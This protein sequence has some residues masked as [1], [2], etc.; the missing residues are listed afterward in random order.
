MF[1][2]NITNNKIFDNIMLSNTNNKAILL[3]KCVIIIYV[4]NLYINISINKVN[5]L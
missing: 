1:N 5:M 3:H 4:A 2:N